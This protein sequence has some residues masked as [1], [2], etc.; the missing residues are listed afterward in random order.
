M[1]TMTY[2]LDTPDRAAARVLEQL[3]RSVRDALLLPGAALYLVGGFVRDA[4]LGRTNRDLDLTVG[5]DALATARQIARRLGAVVV[6]LDAERGAYRVALR[7]LLAGIA[8]VDVTRLRAPAIEADLRLRDFTVNAI[9]VPLADEDGGTPRLIDPMD[10][11]GDLRRKLLRMAGPTAFTDDPLRP[12]RGA[13]LAIELDFTIEEET[14]RAARA[15]A[16]LL[17]QVA[18]ERRR[19]EFSRILASD[20][21]GHGARLMD[22]LGL[23]SVLLPDLDAARGCTQPP[24][25]YYDVFE[26]SLATLDALDALLRH[27]PPDDARERLLWSGAQT[28]FAR[29][30][31]A[32]A[33]LE[34]IAADERPWR[35]TLKFVGLLHDVAKPETRTVEPATGRVRFFGHSERGAERAGA[36][37]R[38][39]R[40]SAR[41]VA[42][43]EK[44]I[45]QHLRPGMLASPGQPPTR[46]ALYRLARDLGEHVPDLF[47]LHLADHAAVRGP[48]L[49]AEEWRQHVAYF[50]ALLAI[51]YSEK[52]ASLPRLITGDDLIAE[53]G[54]RPGPLLGRLLEAVREAQA[55]GEVTDR[56]GALA[57]ARRVLAEEKDD[58]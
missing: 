10:G 3:P 29:V 36:L 14:A 19:D 37:A 5:G 13:R 46:R 35:A 12:L 47:L 31:A 57:L 8:M 11:V 24:E 9:A 26:H 30:P 58:G 23:L 18:A 42:Y 52:V 22:E 41:E 54:L 7:E 15:A 6:T 43:V 21:A 56:A 40:F 55:A 2:L 45:A 50:D 48:R 27:E 28:V 44:L 1:M 51:L 39:L 4:L 16:P 20:A 25:H 34:S 38:A 49:T 32:R 17:T 33:R 53:L